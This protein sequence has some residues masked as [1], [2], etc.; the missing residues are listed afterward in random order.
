MEKRDR[1][2][3]IDVAKGICMI[4][5]VA[6]H[7][8]VK[9]INHVVFS[10]HLTVF[11]IL[12]GFMLKNNLNSQTLGRKFR[13]LM[14]PYFVTCLAVTAMDAVNILLLKHTADFN[15]ITQKIGYDLLR[16][17]LASGSIKNLGSIE[18]GGRI[19]SVCAAAAK[20]CFPG[21]IPLC[22]RH[23]L[24]GAGLCLCAFYLAAFQ[25]SI[26]VSGVTVYFAWL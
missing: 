25:H 5:V 13:S 4:S 15:T 12:S 9:S 16:S 19:G 14:V 10:Y 6:G 18:I 24:C 23:R 11:F 22:H 26:G 7:L 2:Q 1:I 20:I 3:W 21:E 8:N 17:F